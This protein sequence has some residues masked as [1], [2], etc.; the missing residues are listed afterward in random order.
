MKRIAFALLLILPGAADAWAQAGRHVSLGASIGAQQFVDGEN[1][2]SKDPGLSVLYRLSLSSG[3]KSDGWKFE[4]GG[5]IGLSRS[6]TIAEVGGVTTRLGRLRSIPVLVGGGPSNRLGPTSVSLS[7]MGGLSFNSHDVDDGAR[8]AYAAVGPAL[9][10]IE[11]DNAFAMRAGLGAWHDLNSRFGV[12]GSISYL[13][14]RPKMT[15][16]LGGVP[17]TETWQ[18][19]RL[20]IEAGLAVGIF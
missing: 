7:L 13:Y 12:H 14:H 3:A 16:T 18:G 6:R 15:T 1:F 9:G 4:P 17:V 2:E 19:D 8:T 10:G 20:S 11:A 5:S